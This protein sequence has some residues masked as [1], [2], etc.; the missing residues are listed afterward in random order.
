M[1]CHLGDF[2]EYAALRRRLDGPRGRAVASGAGPPARRGR[3]SRSSRCGPGDVIRRARPAAAPGSRSCSTPACAERWTARARTCSTLDRQVRRLSLVDF[4]TPVEPLDRCGSQGLQPAQPAVAPR[5]RR[6]RCAT[7]GPRP[8]GRRVAA[9]RAGGGTR[10]RTRSSL[11]LRAAI[12]AH[13]C[14]GCA[15]REEHARW[16]ERYHRLRPRDRRAAPPRSRAGPTRSPGSS[17]GSATCS[18]ELGYL[19]A[20]T[21]H[22][23]TA[24]RL[25]APLQ[26]ARPAG[27]RVPARRRVG[28]PGRP[29]SWRRALSA[30]VYESRNP[31]TPRRPGS[32]RRGPDGARRDVPHLGRLDALEREHR[33]SFLR[34]PDLGFAWAAYRWA[35][36]HRLDDVLRRRRPG[37][38]ATSCAGCKQLVDLLGPDRRRGGRPAAASRR[39]APRRR[40]LRRRRR[41]APWRARRTPPAVL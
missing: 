25:R 34:E 13:P 18:T 14:H 2:A 31:T 22:A 19:T 17:T 7:R 27:R 36:G 33:L 5:P 28:G 35:G 6:R 10:A 20:T 3:G 8:T 39:T 16:A 15:E 32:R 11:E 24:P 4:P 12:R 1:T 9:A 41:L 40:R 21:G 37:R 23:G 30:L 38:R 26:R 29:P